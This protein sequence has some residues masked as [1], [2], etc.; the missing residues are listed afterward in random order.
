MAHDS[1]RVVIA[2][3][4]STE[5]AGR[6]LDQVLQ[7][8]MGSPFGDAYEAA[9]LERDADGAVS[10]V[11]RHNEPAI[12]DASAGM[13][14]GLAVGVIMAL[15]P[16]VGLGA[17]LLAGAA[18]GA[19]LGAL[20][21]HLAG[22]LSDKDLRELGSVLDDAS[23]GLIVATRNPRRAVYPLLRHATSIV[24]KDVQIPA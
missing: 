23:S 19:G 13:K 10:V 5:A 18:G 21:G 7:L 12:A 3:Y 2:R 16:A 20:S 8:W 22:H 6:D 11:R 15:F 17:G 1:V 24:G 9:V 14:T 4:P